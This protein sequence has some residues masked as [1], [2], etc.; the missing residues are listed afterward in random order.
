ME[1]LENIL[2]DV[3]GSEELINEIKSKIGENFVP[4]N[5]YKKKT[6]KIEELESELET[7]KE[8]LE[9]TTDQLDELKDKAEDK[10]ELQEQLQNIQSEYEEFKEQEEQRIKNIKKKSDLEK[11]LLKNNANEDAVDLLINDFDIEEL[12]LN[13][14]GELEGFNDQ[15]ETVQ[16]KRPTL[17][18]EKKVTGDEPKDG[19]QPN[20]SVNPWKQD[21]LNLTKQAEIMNED[22]KRAKRLIN[23]AGKNPANYGLEQ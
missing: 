13:D 10:E 4:N 5:E 8:Q 7:T 12:E 9:N 16:E 23:A 14:D 21:N 19:D 17:F 6:T 22:P 11:R 15:L 3:E 1:W 18:G 20:E 2:S